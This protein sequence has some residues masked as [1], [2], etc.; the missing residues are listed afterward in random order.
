MNFLQVID[1][2]YLSPETRQRPN[3]SPYWTCSWIIERSF[4]ECGL[5]EIVKPRM[6]SHSVRLINKF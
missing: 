3:V 4:R 5:E 1:L 6:K 2:L